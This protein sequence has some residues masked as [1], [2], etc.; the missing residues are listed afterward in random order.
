MGSLISGFY[1]MAGPFVSAMTNRWG[2]RLITILGSFLAAAAFVA[3]SF[4]TSLGALYILYGVIGG[5]GFS[6]IYI[7]GSF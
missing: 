5:I 1:L 4:T 3:S 2:F 6:M 7:P